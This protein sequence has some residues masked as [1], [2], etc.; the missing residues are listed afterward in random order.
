[1]G[2]IPR[3]T[4]F[5]RGSPNLVVLDFDD[6]EVYE[7]FMKEIENDSELKDIVDNTWLVQTG[8]GF[9]IYIRVDSDK[10]IKIGKL[11]KV[12]IKG[13]GGYVVAPPSLHPNG[14]RYTFIRFSKTTGHEI[15]VISE[16]Q[17]NRLLAVLEKVTGAKL[18]EAKPCTYFVSRF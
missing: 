13:E 3:R 14:K 8:K 7:K 4:T 5:Y 16:E 18:S 17:Y 6:T 2:K 1:M 10:P 9:H 12:D 11:Q 15:R